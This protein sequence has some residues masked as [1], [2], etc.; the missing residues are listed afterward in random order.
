[1]I[2]ATFLADTCSFITLD[3]SWFMHTS[4]SLHITLSAGS[5][6]LMGAQ[7]FFVYSCA[8]SFICANSRDRAASAACEM[9][10]RIIEMPPQTNHMTTVMKNTFIPSCTH[11]DRMSGTLG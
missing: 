7:R 5:R 4:H 8:Q 2:S 10:A 1:M 3:G 11:H 9:S 6:S